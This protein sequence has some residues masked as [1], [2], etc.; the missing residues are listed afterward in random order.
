MGKKICCVTNVLTVLIITRE[1]IN[2]Y[3][4]SQKPFNGFIWSNLGHQNA[5]VSRLDARYETKTQTVAGRMCL[6]VDGARTI[7]RKMEKRDREK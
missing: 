4:F 2:L 3:E 1:K 7:E 5:C 6:L